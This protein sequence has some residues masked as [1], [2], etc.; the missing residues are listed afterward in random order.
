MVKVGK[1]Q[2]FKDHPDMLP[3]FWHPAAPKIAAKLK[4]NPNLGLRPMICLVFGGHCFSGNNP[5]R[6]MRG[7]EP[8][9]GKLP[10]Y[11]EQAPKCRTKVPSVVS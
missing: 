1:L 2:K 4:K 7:L 5:C 11:V 10:S 9:T 6:K 3:A 8:R